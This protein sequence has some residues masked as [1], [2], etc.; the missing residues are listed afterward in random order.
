MFFQTRRTSWYPGGAI[1][2]G[3]HGIILCNV[4][5]NPCQDCHACD[6]A[7]AGDSAADLPAAPGQLPQLLWLLLQVGRYHHLHR[8]LTLLLR[9][10]WMKDLGGIK[11][12]GLARSVG[13]SHI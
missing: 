2:C 3:Y 1:I 12:P 13:R 4:V 7:D 10:Q 5:K 6:Q 9:H 11:V 8:L